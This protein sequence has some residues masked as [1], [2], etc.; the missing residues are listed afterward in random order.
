M[1]CTNCGAQVAPNARFCTTCGTPMA[2]AQPVAQVAAPA[3]PDPAAQASGASY[4]SQP[5]QRIDLPSPPVVQTGE[6]YTGIDYQVVGTT[7]QAVIIQLEPGQTV[8]SES[9]GMSWMSSIPWPADHRSRHGRTPS[10][11]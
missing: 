1:Q 3:M 7:L 9:G 5:G 4:S 8:Y 6:G 11:R 2:G 10:G